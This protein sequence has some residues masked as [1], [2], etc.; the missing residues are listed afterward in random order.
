MFFVGVVSRVSDF[1]N[2]L[3]VLINFNCRYWIVRTGFIS[4]S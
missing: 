3:F 1:G 2:G 4:S